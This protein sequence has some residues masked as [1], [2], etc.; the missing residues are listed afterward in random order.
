ML[1]SISGT[2]SVFSLTKR[3]PMKVNASSYRRIENETAFAVPGYAFA[4]FIAVYT[5]SFPTYI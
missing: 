4:V 2:V 3:R 5:H 1:V